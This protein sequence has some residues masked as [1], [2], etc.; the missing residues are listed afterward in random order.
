MNKMKEWFELKRKVVS[1]LGSSVVVVDSAY[2]RKWHGSFDFWDLFCF[3]CWFC[4]K[5]SFE[6]TKCGFTWFIY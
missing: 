2:N 3:V 1:V 6:E 5:Y 4:I